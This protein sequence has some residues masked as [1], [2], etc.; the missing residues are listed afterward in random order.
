LSK[1]ESYDYI[2]AGAGLS[3]LSLAYKIKNDPLLRH[4]RLLMIDPLTK[5][6]NDRTWC[7]WSC[8]EDYFD[9]ILYTRWRNI[10]FASH[11]FSSDY[12]IEPY[13]YKMIR[14]I[15]FYNKV[16]PFLEADPHTDWV[17]A[18]IAELGTHGDHV[19]AKTESDI[20]KGSHIFKSY[21][22]KTDFSNAH[23][24]WQH[25]KGWI[26]ET[27]HDTFDPDRATFM[28]FRVAQ[29]DETR[30]FY[31][32]PFSDSKALV[33][34]AIFSSSIPDPE[35]YDPF[36]ESYIKEQLNISSYHIKETEL[37]AIPMTTFPF[38]KNAMKGVTQIGTA[39]GS[40]KASSGYAFQRIQEETDAILQQ[41]KSGNNI[42]APRPANRYHFYDRIL[43]NVILNGKVTGER[44]FEL[45]FSKLKPQTIFRFLDEKGGFLNDIKVFTA[46][47]TLPFM[48]AF[49]EELIKGK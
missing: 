28:D 3:G 47:P 36:L 14:G 9:D 49:C 41:M 1:E 22:D 17:K 10:R 25:F 31:V 20:F 15:D 16:V 37:G 44:V 7:F 27:D 23:F 39:S 42:S 35:F 24:V 46:P 43:L 4:K 11:D 26:I 30:F 38:Q 45:L 5:N 19:F 32:L 12:N 8:E 29:E 40:V 48:K 6:S 2:F 18:P 33:E 21:Y 13:S 34:I